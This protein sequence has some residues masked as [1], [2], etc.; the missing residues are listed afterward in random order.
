MKVSIL[1]DWFDTVRTLPCFAKPAAH[2]V[3]IWNEHV[4]DT[5]VL[6]H[7]LRD[8]EARVLI[9]ER[10]QVRMPLLERLPRLQLISQCSV[11]PHIDVDTCTR[12]GVVVSSNQHAD[13]PPY[14]TA[15]LT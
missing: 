8:T 4:Q 13:T 3:T 6:V 12:R 15:E 11:Y 14:A 9:R 7:R 2:D 5:S 10:T 1:D